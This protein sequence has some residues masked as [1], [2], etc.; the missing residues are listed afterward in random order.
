MPLDDVD[1]ANNKSIVSII[2]IRKTE[3]YPIKSLQYEPEP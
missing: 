3:G 2:N 1:V